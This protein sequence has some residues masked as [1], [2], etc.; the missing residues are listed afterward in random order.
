MNLEYIDPSYKPKRTDLIAEYTLKPAQGVSLREACEAIAG[1]SSIGTWTTIHTMT[2]KIAHK[3]KPHIFSIKGSSIKVAYNEELFEP[4]N[5]PQVLSSIAGNIF[6]MKKLASLR[7]ED[8]E[9]TKKLVQNFKGPRFGIQGIRKLTKVKDRPLVGTI[10]KPKLGLNSTQHA[11]VAYQSWI[12]GCDIVKDDENLTSMS[13]NKFRERVRKTLEARK[14]AE[15]ETGEVK[16]YMPNATAETKELLDRAYFIKKQG[17]RYV[18]MDIMTCGWSAVQTLRNVDLGLVIHAHRAMHAALTRNKDHGISMLTIA[19]I[20]RLI[21]V[22]QL[23]IGTIVGKMVGPAVEVGSIEGEIEDN[24]IREKGHVL[25]QKWYGLKPTFAVCSGGLHPGLVDNLMGKLGKNII[26]QAGGG[27]HGHPSG[28][29]AGARAMRQSVDAM[30]KKQTL[31]DY[32]KKHAELKQALD[33]W[34]L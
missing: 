3:L 34:G 29:T 1:E 8:I 28:T 24:L 32:A 10:V 33:E 6:G 18:M 25:E 17:G 20:A 30:M 19:K 9:F 27:I 15:R 23:H 2:P 13:F 4:G 7:L 12:G 16:I 11:K 5:I 31:R 21:G 22:D 26:I 14:K